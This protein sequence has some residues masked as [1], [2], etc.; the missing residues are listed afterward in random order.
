M[1]YVIEAYGGG[2]I[3]VDYSGKRGQFGAAYTG[4]DGVWRSQPMG[5]TPFETQELANQ[6]V[7]DLKE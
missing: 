6:F 3:V 1:N 4:S 7:K 5:M 2:F